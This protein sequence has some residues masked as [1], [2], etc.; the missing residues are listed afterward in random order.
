MLG[1]D[2]ILLA[3]FGQVG[4]DW[5]AGGQ[6]DWDSDLGRYSLIDVRMGLFSRFTVEGPADIAA[7]QG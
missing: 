2:L 5:Q 1:V 6:L 3:G 7:F 4:L